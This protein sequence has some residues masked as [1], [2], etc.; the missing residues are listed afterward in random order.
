MKLTEVDRDR[1]SAKTALA[2]AAKQAEDQHQ[3]RRRIE[4]QL[5]ITNEQIE[6]LKKK[7][8]KAEETI[9]QAEQE[10]NDIGVKEMEENLRAQVIGV[11]QAYCLQIWTEA[12]TWLG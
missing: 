7:V 10:G 11:C 9:A 12:L 4:D 3:Q 1:K 6:T 2:R 8:E 5:V